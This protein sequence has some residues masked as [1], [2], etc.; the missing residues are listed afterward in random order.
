MISHDVCVIYIYTHIYIFLNRHAFRWC[1]DHPFDRGISCCWRSV[2]PFVFSFWRRGELGRP[3]KWNSW[4]ASLQFP[5]GNREIIIQIFHSQIELPSRTQSGY[6]TTALNDFNKW[7]TI[8]PAVGLIKDLS[9]LV[10]ARWRWLLWVDF[11]YG[12]LRFGVVMVCACWLAR[13]TTQVSPICSDPHFWDCYIF[14]LCLWCI[15]IDLE[16]VIVFQITISIRMLPSIKTD[17]D[18]CSLQGRAGSG[19][20]GR[21]KRHATGWIGVW[22]R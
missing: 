15:P 17:R 13:V 10:A 7:Y 1:L 5:M 2:G 4:A 3:G 8:G 21:C 19:R 14:C 11:N 6:V 9:S 20:L 18:P 12:F 22:Q 16:P